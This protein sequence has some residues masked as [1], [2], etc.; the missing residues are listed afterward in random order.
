MLIKPK[1]IGWI[2]RVKFL[3]LIRRKEHGNI[4]QRCDEAINVLARLLDTAIRQDLLHPSNV[5]G[6]LG[7][8]GRFNDLSLG[9]TAFLSLVFAMTISPVSGLADSE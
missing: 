9:W 8:N 7:F 2:C 4:L 1:P 3:G 6:N 5:Q